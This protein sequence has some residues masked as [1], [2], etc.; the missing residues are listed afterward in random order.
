MMSGVRIGLIGD[1]EGELSAA[2]NCLRKLGEQRL[3]APASVPFH[4]SPDPRNPAMPRILAPTGSVGTTKPAES[5][6]GLRRGPR[7]AAL[8]ARATHGSPRTAPDPANRRTS[9]G[10]TP[11]DC[12]FFLVFCAP[13]FADLGVPANLAGI[14][15]ER[16]ITVPTPIQQVTLPDSLAG[17]DVLGRG[18][19]GSGKTYAFL[20]PVVARL[21]ASR[22]TT[23]P[24]APRALILAPTRELVGQI[25]QAL[26]PLATAA[27][28]TT[29]TIFGGVSQV[30]Q[31][32]ALQRGAD[33]VLA[34]PGRLEDLIKQR[35]CSLGD[36]EVTVL[37]EADHMADLGFLPAVRR[38]L[39]ADPAHRPAAALLRDAGR[40]HRHAGQALPQPAGHPP[41]RLGAVAGLGD[42]PPRA[43]RRPRPPHPGARRPDQRPRAHHGLHPHQARRQGAGPPAQR[44]R[45][46][47]GRDARQ[48]QPGRPHPQHGGVPRRPATTLVA[49]DIAARGIHVDDVALVVHADPPME[50]KAYLHRSGRTARAGAA[51]TVIT[52]MTDEQVRDVRA[53]TRAAGIKPTHDP[54]PGCRAPGAR[55][56]WP[57]ASA[58]WSPAASA[59]RPPRS[60][61]SRRG[62]GGS[63]RPARQRSG[64]SGNGGGGRAASPRRASPSRAR[65]PQ[66]GHLGQA[67]RWRRRPSVAA[68]RRGAPA[69]RLRWRS[70]AQ[71]GDLQLALSLTRRPAAH[72]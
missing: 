4:T 51:G 16:G 31:V 62:G 2:V 10:E 60:S 9:V 70:L 48:P 6:L 66:G 44:Q 61:P 34:C 14:L 68:A 5:Y 52:L 38:I 3:G 72:P 67:L 59:S 41:G 30:P 22:R 71:R 23:R 18:R 50:H 54:G 13:S 49:T 53:L 1:L 45:R 8:L 32:N 36:I 7:S 21:A 35:H 24:G 43:A 29:M 64:G 25:E 33:I 12:D 40:G 47:R 55:S 58:R 27:G 65:P 69:A 20:L 28:L 11:T 37:D 46:A 39:G 26:K 57:R 19:T 63:G 42:G 56:S 15:A 17:R